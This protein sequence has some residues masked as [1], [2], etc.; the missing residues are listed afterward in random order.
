VLSVVAAIA[1]QLVFLNRHA[2]SKDITYE[3]WST[4]LCQQIAQNLSIIT[5]CL[6]CLHPFILD[7]LS[8]TIKAEEQRLPFPCPKA[9]KVKE[10]VQRRRPRFDPTGSASSQSS[11]K[12][13]NEKEEPPSYLHPLAT[14]GLDRSSAHVNSQH[15]TRFPSNAP[16]P[17]EGPSP[18]ENVFMRS[19]AIPEDDTRPPTS[20]SEKRFPFPSYPKSLAQVGVL[21]VADWDTEGSDGSSERSNRSRNPDSQYV[22][23]RAKVIS[24]PEANAFFAEEAWRKYPSPPKSGEK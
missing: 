13:L 3:Y 18:P 12:P 19:I 17:I 16:T 6:P 5:A 20:C 2:Y 15:F 8:G 4:A 1:A 14:Y 7:V 24:V 21:P 22:F 10:Y 11:T 9:Q 23:D